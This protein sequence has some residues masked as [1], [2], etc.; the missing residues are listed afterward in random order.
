MTWET[1]EAVV[2]NK[3]SDELATV[4]A[5]ATVADAGTVIRS[6]LPRPRTSAATVCCSIVIAP[7]I[8]RSRPA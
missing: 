8:S 1:V 3:A 2:R 4:E 5:S 7:P 6:S